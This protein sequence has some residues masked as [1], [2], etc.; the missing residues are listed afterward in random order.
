MEMWTSSFYSARTGGE[1]VA[2]SQV[3]EGLLA[4]P[5]CPLSA[6]ASCCPCAQ[7]GAPERMSTGAGLPR[8]QHLAVT[9]DRNSSG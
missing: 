9:R 1:A 7:S 2:L 3:V 8:T 5:E 6:E 4:L